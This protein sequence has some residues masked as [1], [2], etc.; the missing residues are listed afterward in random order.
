MSDVYTRP[1]ITIHWV[2]V[3]LVAAQF[4]T[5][6]AMETFFDAAE[7]AKAL[8]G[9]PTD[10]TAMA[11]AIG[12]SI[13]ALLT[14]LRLGLR[15]TC[16]APPAPVSLAPILKLASRITHYSFYVLL[17]ALPMTGAAA[18]YLTPEAGDVHVVLKTVLV[19]FVLAHVAGA[20]V[21]AFVLKDGIIRRMI[22]WA[23]PM[24]T[25]Q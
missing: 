7:K 4:L 18:L 19:V 11:H 23:R 8:A 20:L 10:P 24:K 25:P 13:V 6:E 5:A 22:P 15:L 3:G 1:Q 16:D 21:H 12:G 17:I 9:F 2:I 14:L